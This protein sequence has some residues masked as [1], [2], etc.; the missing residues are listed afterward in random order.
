MLSGFFLCRTLRTILALATILSLSSSCLAQQPNFLFLFADDYGR[1]ASTYAKLEPNEPLQGLVRTPNIDR[2]AQRGVL[3]RKAF[4]SAPSCTPCRSAL[5][6]GQHFWRT[7]EASILQGAKWEPSLPA[8]PLLLHEA[9]YHIGES[10]KVWSPGSPVDAPYGA[11]KFAYEKSGRRWNDFSENATEMLR[12]GIPFE[13]AKQTLLDEMAS[14]FD[15]FLGDRPEGK[16]FCYWFGP[17]NV[18][19]Q[20]VQGSGKRLWGFDPEEFKGKL[21]AFL[22]D[23]PIVREDLADYFGEI[24]AYD[25]AVGML[26]AR[27]ESSGLADSTMVIVSGDHGPPG[28]PHGK[29]N[30]YDFGTSVALAIC[31]PQIPADR[32]IDDLVSLTDIAPTILESAGL[33]IPE[34]MTG[35]SL[36]PMLRSDR[37]GK[38]DSNR[39]A[40]FVGRERHV[41]SARADFSPYPQRAIRT[42]EH[43]LIINFRP[44]R[45]P[46]GDPYGLDDPEPPTYEQIQRNTRATHPDEDAGPTKAWLVTHRNDPLWNPFY[47]RAYGKRPRVELYDLRSDPHQMTNVA[48]DPKYQKIRIELED[49]LIKELTATGDPRVELEGQFYETPPMS[50][51]LVQKGPRA[52]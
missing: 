39:T 20:W 37:S 21:P 38:L 30:L 12:Q 51:P 19:R 28:F 35:K 43:L 13:E 42:D 24:A 14:N 11:G 49:R 5:L 7:K 32:T 15:Q 2:I 23:V 10:F 8:F 31:G 41:E 34:S 29:C 25:A 9:G 22:P 16:P 47:Q 45:W 50:G 6:S 17:T 18:H 46:L 4:V 27:L 1:Y 36:L 3:F 44:E 48:Q 52:R 26:L 33:P 40:V